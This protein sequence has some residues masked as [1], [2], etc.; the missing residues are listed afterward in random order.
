MQL[1]P[2]PSGV[3]TGLFHHSSIKPRLSRAGADFLL[4][5]QTMRLQQSVNMDLHLLLC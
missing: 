2:V 1:F 3:T 5:V 4:L